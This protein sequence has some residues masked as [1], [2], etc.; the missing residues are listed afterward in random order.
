MWGKRSKEMYQCE[1]VVYKRKYIPREKV[2]A[3]VGSIKI[4]RMIHL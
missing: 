1:W 2:F 4:V 3:S